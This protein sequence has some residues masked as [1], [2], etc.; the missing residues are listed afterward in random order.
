MMKWLG[1]GATVLAIAGL[2][3]FGLVRVVGDSMMSTYCEGDRLLTLP[4]GS[5]ESLLG[6]V[7]VIVHPLH[8]VLIKRVVA[9]AGDVLQVDSG[10][11]RVNGRVVPRYAFCDG[12]DFTGMSVADRLIHEEWVVPHGELYVLGDYRNGSLD[13]RT[14]GMVRRTDVV[15]VVWSRLPGFQCRCRSDSATGAGT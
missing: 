12:A 8:G 10:E 15:G 14:Y 5:G 6:R 9:E 4:P 13:S 1:A 11:I 7:V 2:L 3:L